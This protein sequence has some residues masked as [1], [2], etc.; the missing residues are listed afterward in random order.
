MGTA[1]SRMDLPERPGSRDQESR[2]VGRGLPD[3]TL[4]R[5]G[6]FRLGGRALRWTLDVAVVQRAS[7]GQSP[8]GRQLHQEQLDWW[9]LVA[10]YE[11]GKKHDRLAGS[12][13]KR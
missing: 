5:L 13:P 6:G 12:F 1:K 4:P 3:R 7:T 9:I 10:G 2:G 11:H 8:E